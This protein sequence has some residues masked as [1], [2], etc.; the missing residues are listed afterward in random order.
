MKM[1]KRTEK[2]S[3]RMRKDILEIAEKLQREYDYSKADIFEMG[4]LLLDNDGNAS[5]TLKSELYDKLIERFTRMEENVHKHCDSILT[6]I[7]ENIS[8]L[9]SEKE[10]LNT[11]NMESKDNEYDMRLNECLEYIISII[12]M[13]QDEKKYGSRGKI[14]EPLGSGFY[15]VQ[16]ERYV[17][18]L[19]DILDGLHNRGYDDELLIDLGMN[20]HVKW[21][22]YSTASKESLL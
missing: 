5:L 19:S 1:N 6:G 4:V 21:R 11:F 13:R 12:D 17:V 14:F 7:K 9:Q 2:T 16:A 3:I 15:E 8:E 22:G 18:I 10:N 20:P